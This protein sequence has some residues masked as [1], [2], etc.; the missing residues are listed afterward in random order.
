MSKQK[1]RRPTG[2]DNKM[3]EQRTGY[4]AVVAIGYKTDKKE[5]GKMEG[6]E[7]VTINNIA[8]LSKVKKNDVVILARTGK[9]KKMEIA[10]KAQEA[11]IQIQNLN[12]RKFLKK[13][14]KKEIPKAAKTEAKK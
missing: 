1:W 6:K 14:E 12:A 4:P 3:R 8:D 2:R 13:N 7:P 11:G 5:R 10:K 9:K